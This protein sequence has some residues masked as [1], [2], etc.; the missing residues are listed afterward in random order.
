MNKVLL[1]VIS[2]LVLTTASLSLAHQDSAETQLTEL[3]EKY[4]LDQ[5]Q[6]TLLSGVIESSRRLK[7]SLSAT[8]GLKGQVKKHLLQNE[9]DP[10]V[11]MTD[12]RQWNMQFEIDLAKALDQLAILHSTLSDDQRQALIHDLEE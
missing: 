12:Y 9:L 5:H 1:I 10:A 3:A 7:A 8:G 11:I 2:L 6:Q 4:Q